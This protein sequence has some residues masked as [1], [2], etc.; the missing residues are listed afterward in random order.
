VGV[1]DSEIQRERERE[2]E[3]E[4]ARER[5]RRDESVRICFGRP[6]GVGPRSDIPAGCQHNGS[7]KALLRLFQALLRL[8]EGMQTHGW[9]SEVLA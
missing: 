9:R 2:R 3:R 4:R 1:V 5:E 8:Y 6:Q 7:I